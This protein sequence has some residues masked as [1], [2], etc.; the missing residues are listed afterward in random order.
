MTIID[1]ISSDVFIIFKIEIGSL[2]VSSCFLPFL[3]VFLSKG[4]IKYNVA[5]GRVNYT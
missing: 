1:N 4:L 5:N 3:S 2:I